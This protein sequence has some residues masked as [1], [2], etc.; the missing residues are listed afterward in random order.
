MLWRKD[1]AF[2]DKEDEDDF[3]EGG[4]EDKGVELA[5]DGDWAIGGGGGGMTLRCRKVLLLSDS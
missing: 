3:V 4:G 2:R 5:D 1:A